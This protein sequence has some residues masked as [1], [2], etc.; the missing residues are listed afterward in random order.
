MVLSGR[1][2]PGMRCQYVILY[3]SK[4]WGHIYVYI[5]LNTISHQGCIKWI[6]IDSKGNLVACDSVSFFFTS[7]S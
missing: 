3:Y 7:E 4:F 5:L 2:L 6:R 1:C